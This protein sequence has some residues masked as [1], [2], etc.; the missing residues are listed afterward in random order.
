[1]ALLNPG[2]IAADHLYAAMHLLDRAAVLP[3]DDAKPDHELA[4][5]IAQACATL[6]IAATMSELIG[7]LDSLLSADSRTGGLNDDA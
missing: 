4:V 1:M 6:A 2:N 5:A 7:R 3:D